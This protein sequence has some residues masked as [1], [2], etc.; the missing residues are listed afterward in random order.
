MLYNQ[1]YNCC[2]IAREIM[3]SV[4]LLREKLKGSFTPQVY[5]LSELLLLKNKL[6]N[7]FQVIYVRKK[8]LTSEIISLGINTIK[9]RCWLK[10]LIDPRQLL[11]SLWKCCT[12]AISVRFLPS[13][14]TPQRRNFLFLYSLS[15]HS[16]F[17]L[18]HRSPSDLWCIY[19][20]VFICVLHP[21]HW[22]SVF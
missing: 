7:Q 2:L 14:R 22:L 15:F 9:S 17:A 18:P 20:C 21:E 1:K 5:L 13:Q 3:F 4:Q 10:I 8:A 19:F 11:I 6:K 12:W 16:C